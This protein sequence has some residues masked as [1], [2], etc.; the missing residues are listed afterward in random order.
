[1]LP[2][3][4]FLFNPKILGGNP[5]LA[6]H[7]MN[8]YVYSTLYMRETCIE[9]V[10]FENEKQYKHT[11]GIQLTRHGWCHRLNDP[12]HRIRNLHTIK[13]TTQDNNDICNITAGLAE[14]SPPPPRCNMYCYILALPDQ[15]GQVTNS[16]V[17]GGV[18]QSG[19]LCPCKLNFMYVCVC[20][21]VNLYYA[22][23]FMICIH[24]YL[25]FSSMCVCVCVC[26]CGMRE[27]PWTNSMWRFRIQPGRE[28]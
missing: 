8:T 14:L 25:L 9:K 28:L 26:I 5:A 20:T 12:S 17:C 24:M 6:S 21:P 27:Q 16:G 4:S 22:F 15:T 18:V 1:M 10:Y 13:K 3:C 23:I 2:K 11:R 19:L 7:C